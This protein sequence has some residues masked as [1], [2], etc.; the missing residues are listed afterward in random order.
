MTFKEKRIAKKFA[1]KI[2]KKTIYDWLFSSNFD[3]WFWDRANEYALREDEID[4]IIKNLKK[5]VDK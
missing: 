1:K 3:E 2:V 5:W 4:Y